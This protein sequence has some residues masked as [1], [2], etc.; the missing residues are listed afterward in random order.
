MSEKSFTDNGLWGISQNLAT[1]KCKAKYYPNPDG[2]LRLGSVECFS[3][4]AFRDGKYE[5]PKQIPEGYFFHLAQVDEARKRGDADAY[6]YHIEMLQKYEREYFDEGVLLTAKA[7]DVDGDPKE[8]A[9]A[10][11]ADTRAR[12]IRRAKKSCFDLIMCNHDLDAFVTL[13]FDPSRVNSR[14]YDEVYDR[15]RG[16]LSN[17]VQRQGLKYILV[18]EFHKDGEK[19]HFHALMNS[20]ALKLVFA[21]YPN[22]RLIKQRRNGVEKQLFNVDDWEFGFS[23][24]ELISGDDAQVRISK[25]VFKY[26]GKNWGTRIGGR[27]YLHGG[28]LAL[29]TYAYS[30]DPSE[31]FELGSENYYRSYEVLPG[32]VYEEYS[33]I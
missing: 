27:Y 2:S 4:P 16:W 11:R 20:S 25:Y 12:A 8:L 30:D 1:H 5:K 22:G 14:S 13:T 6:A 19:I 17:R 24:A 15:I 21:R 23:E 3:V 33:L 31:F 28:K 26:M 10:D 29:P 18:P 32:I 9:A 7:V